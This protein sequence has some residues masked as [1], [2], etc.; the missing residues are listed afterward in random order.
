M[1]AILSADVRRPESLSMLLAPGSESFCIFGEG[2]SVNLEMGVVEVGDT[3]G[4]EN[5]PGVCATA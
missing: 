2:L 5:R 1:S 3:C 4:A